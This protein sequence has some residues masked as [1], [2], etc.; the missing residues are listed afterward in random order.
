MIRVNRGSVTV[1]TEI[2]DVKAGNPLSRL[3]HMMQLEKGRSALMDID[4]PAFIRKTLY[5][6]L[7]PKGPASQKLSVPA[8]ISRLLNFVMGQDGVTFPVEE[9][10]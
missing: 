7:P 10:F 8:P 3:A 9:S 1:T 5:L 2:C 6:G 4:S